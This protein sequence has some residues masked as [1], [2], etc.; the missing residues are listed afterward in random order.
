MAALNIE[1]P[2]ELVTASGRS[3]EQ[4][5]RELKFQFAVRLFQVGWLSL[6]KAAELAGMNK[7]L[8][9]DELGRLKISIVNWDDEELAA[10]LRA[11]RGDH[12][13]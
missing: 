6:G 3:R 11:I 13:R 8:F 12:H 5:E 2:D 1:Y 10:E 4:V 9:M 7:I